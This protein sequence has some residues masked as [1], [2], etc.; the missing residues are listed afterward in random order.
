MPKSTAVLFALCCTLLLPFTVQ[1]EPDLIILVRHAEKSADNLADPSLSALGQARAQALAIALQHSAVSNIFTTQFKR[2]RETALPL[3]QA[4]GI[5]PQVLG[6]KRGAEHINE[7]VAAVRASTGVVLVV[8]HSNTV[9]AIA[10]ALG[11]PAMKDFCESSFSHL[12]LLRPTAQGVYMVQ[13]RY[14]VAEA[15]STD[16]NCQ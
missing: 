10:S 3:A 8:G 13:S 2:T 12:L 14:G 15:S 16:A 6:A 5:T 7:V 1:A 4:R 9:P 11:A